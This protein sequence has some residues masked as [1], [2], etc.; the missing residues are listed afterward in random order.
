LS[1]PAVV[2]GLVLT[3]TVAVPALGRTNTTAECGAIAAGFA[4][5]TGADPG[6]LRIDQDRPAVLDG[7]S[8]R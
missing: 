1:L 4:E 8:V 6:V 2:P 7:P 3:Y 5:S